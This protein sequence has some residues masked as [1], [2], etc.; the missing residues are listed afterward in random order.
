MNYTRPNDPD[1]EDNANDWLNSAL[2][3]ASALGH[4]LRE[5]EGVIVDIKN[6]MI[7]TLPEEFEGYEKL[8]VFRAAGQ[9][10]IQGFD[11]DAPEGTMVMMWQDN[12][13]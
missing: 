9:I 11:E 1:Y 10:H 3:F 2:I 7:D 12:P 5:E 13:N 6:D 4:I 8:I